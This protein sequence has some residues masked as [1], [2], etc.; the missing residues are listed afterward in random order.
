[1][2][3]LPKRSCNSRWSAP[4]LSGPTCSSWMPSA[5]S[6]CSN[7]EAWTPPTRRRASS[8]SRLSEVSRR[9]ANASAPADDASSHW[10]SSIASRSGASSV[11]NCSALRVAIPSARGSTAS[12]VAS[13]MRSATPS[14]RRLGAGNV[15]RT[16]RARPRTNRSTP[17]EQDRARPPQVATRGPGTQERAHDRH[18]QARASIF[19]YPLRPRARVPR[20]QHPIDRGRRGGRRAPHLC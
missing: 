1:M 5:P 16:C 7:A 3:C 9:N 18:P 12:A 20:A 19:R 17:R 14:A 13:S 10:R 15:G 8:R 4:T 6:A 2:K 11:R